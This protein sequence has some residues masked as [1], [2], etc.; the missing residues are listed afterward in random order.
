M[1]DSR[2]GCAD[3]LRQALLVDSGN[4]RFGS[5]FLAQ[6]GDLAKA[7]VIDPT[8]VTRF[9]LQNAGSI[10]ALMLTTEALVAD[11]REKEHAPAGPP[12]GGMGGGDF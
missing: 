2:P 5:A 8:K 11:L 3:H 9:A 12:H 10:A 6:F 7:G 4:Y 1:T